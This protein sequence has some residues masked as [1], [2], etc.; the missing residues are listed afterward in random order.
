MD[1]YLSSEAEII[2]PSKANRSTFPVSLRSG[3]QARIM[4]DLEVMICNTANSFLMCEA[5]SGRI[6]P[7]SV[8]RAASHWENRNRPQVVEFLY[9]QASQ[10]DLIVA[11]LRTVKFYGD[12]ANDAF[13][14]NSVLYQWKV[15]A[16]EMTPRTFCNPDSTIKRWVHDGYRVLELLNAKSEVLNSCAHLNT[17]VWS[18]IA[19]KQRER[20]QRRDGS[21]ST[22]A[23]SLHV[24]SISDGQHTLLQSV[25]AHSLPTRSATQKTPPMPTSNSFTDGMRNGSTVESVIMQMPR[26]RDSDSLRRVKFERG[27]SIQQEISSHTPVMPSPDA[28]SMRSMRSQPL[29]RFNVN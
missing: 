22:Q 6:S 14:L 5:Q 3:A 2:S 18:Q 12:A 9:D 21:G 4:S 23:P 28:G 17:L 7:E 13:S 20:A 15:M 27:N 24:R 10:H 8:A 29:Y 1:Q 26:L 25:P 19:E 11:N 16:R